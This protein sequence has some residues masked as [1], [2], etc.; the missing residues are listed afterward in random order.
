MGNIIFV[1][2]VA[3]IL[4][5]SNST[6]AKY[7]NLGKIPIMG[8]RGKTHFYDEDVVQKLVGTLGIRHTSKKGEKKAGPDYFVVTAARLQL[9]ID[10]L[11]Q[12]RDEL[13]RLI[14]G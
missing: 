5:C 3:K 8:K 12:R 14:A 13:E 11:V 10:K 7:T 2:E 4:G 6:A 9:Q 1:E